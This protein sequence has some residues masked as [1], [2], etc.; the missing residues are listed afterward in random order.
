MSWLQLLLRFVLLVLLQYFR[1]VMGC[2]RPISRAFCL[3]PKSP[4]PPSH[5]PEDV[6][7]HTIK[8]MIFNVLQETDQLFSHLHEGFSFSDSVVIILLYDKDIYI[9]LIFSQHV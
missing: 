5:H 4:T 8:T 3:P 1:I 2:F 9:I 7:P 6:Y